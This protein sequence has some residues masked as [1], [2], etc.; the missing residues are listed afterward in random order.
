MCVCVCVCRA[1]GWCG[2]VDVSYYCD[3]FCM[4]VC[5]ELLGGVEKL[6]LLGHVLSSLEK[7]TDADNSPPHE[8]SPQ[9]SPT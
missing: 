7:V 6:K 9:T 4:C 1:S 2:E 5:R 8:H 3:F